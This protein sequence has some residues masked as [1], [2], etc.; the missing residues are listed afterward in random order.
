VKP[1]KIDLLPAIARE[2]IERAIREANFSGYAELAERF[3]RLGKGISKSSLHRYAVKLKDRDQRA[4]FEAEVMAHMGDEPAYLVRWARRNPE[5]AARLV[6]RL[7]AQEE[8][9]ECEDEKRG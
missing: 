9:L 4:K 6:K 1:S 8:K 2:M 3:K 7:R 5:A